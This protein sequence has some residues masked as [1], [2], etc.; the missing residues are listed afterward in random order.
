MTP[1]DAP[2]VKLAPTPG[3]QAALIAGADTFIDYTQ[4]YG[5]YDPSKVYGIVYDQY[6][7]LSSENAS[8]FDLTANYH[9]AADIGSFDLFGNG[10]WLRFAERATAT[11]P[12]QILSGTIFNPPVFKGARRPDLVRHQLVGHRHRQPHQPGD[13]LQLRCRRPRPRPGRPPIS[14]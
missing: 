5:P 4:K 1:A 7:N 6:Q 10:S 8:G 3:Q 12:T 2:F 9:I 13:R 11:A 14:R